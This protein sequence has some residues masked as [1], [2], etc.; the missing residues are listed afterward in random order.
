M[1]SSDLKIR[2]QMGL[3]P[4][5][6]TRSTR[7]V[8]RRDKVQ[9]QQKKP[10]AKLKQDAAKN[11][12]LAKL[13]VKAKKKRTKTAKTAR[14]AKIPSQKSLMSKVLDNSR[15]NT[16]TKPVKVRKLGN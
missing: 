1:C 11:M 4:L 12:R 3:S 14:A 8:T 7:R 10:K 9:Q 6:S 5:P 16:P 2:Q 15:R 13:A